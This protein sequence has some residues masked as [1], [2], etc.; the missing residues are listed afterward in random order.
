MNWM[1]ALV[2]GVVP[3][4]SRPPTSPRRE[5]NVRLHHFAAAD[6]I[7]T[8]LRRKT[9]RTQI[10]LYIPWNWALTVQQGAIFDWLSRNLVLRRSIN[11][12]LARPF[13]P[14]LER[15]RNTNIHGT[16]LCVDLAT[17]IPEDD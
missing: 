3:A 17:S 8:Y 12:V 2:P 13:Y 4:H 15:F 16:D 14:R 7:G 6:I 1:F 9:T 10:A 5:T 11:D